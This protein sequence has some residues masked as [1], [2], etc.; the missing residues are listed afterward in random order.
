LPGSVLETVNSLREAYVPSTLEAATAVAISEAI[1]GSVS[2]VISRST[3][4]A[5]GDT[6]K[7]SLNTKIA[8][9]TAFF[10]TRGLLS[11]AARILGLPK[12]VAFLASVVIS[13]VVSELAKAAG[14]QSDN[15]IKS[16]KSEIQV[17]LNVPEVAGDMTKWIVYDVLY[18]YD[19][20]GPDMIDQSVMSF[21][22][23][24]TAAMA[25]VLMNFTVTALQLWYQRLLLAGGTG[26][27]ARDMTQHRPDADARPARV[28]KTRH[29]D[30]LLL[31]PQ[32]LRLGQASLEGGVM[33]LSFQTVLSMLAMTV[34]PKYNYKFAFNSFLEYMQSDLTTRGV[35]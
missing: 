29:T 8:A 31:S 35:S 15:A 26:T 3:A 32:L 13:A 23:G 17:K 10:G 4:N 11:T 25:G 30:K 1:A 7:D 27:A 22:Y 20:H 12:P 24:A 34:P 19:H 6:K 16:I 14:R 28:S 2:G 21:S 18:H 9:T 5:I 33:F